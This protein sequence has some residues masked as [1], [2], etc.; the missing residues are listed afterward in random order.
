M[1]P[2]A[3]ICHKLRS[4]GEREVP[5]ARD[6]RTGDGRAAPSG[7]SGL[8]ALRL[9]LSQLPGRGCVPAR[10]RPA[11]TPAPAPAASRPAVAAAGRRARIAAQARSHDRRHRAGP[12]RIAVRWRARFELAQRGLYTTDPNP[13]VG[14]VLVRDGQVV[15]EGWHERAGGPH[16]EAACAARWRASAARGATAY[17][18]LEPCDHHGRTP[19]CSLALID[20]GVARVVYAMRRSQSARGGRRRGAAARAAASPSRPG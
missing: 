18:T 14:C 8:C 7:R 1:T 3:R 6:R 15:G 4:M 17:V 13:R 10:D 16:A 5:V 2:S 20:A 9:G 12:T 11:A 19:P